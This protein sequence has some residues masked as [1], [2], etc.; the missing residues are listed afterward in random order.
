WFNEPRVFPKEAST[1]EGG[2]RSVAGVAPSNDRSIYEKC[3]KK[4]SVLLLSRLQILLNSRHSSTK[5]D[6]VERFSFLVSE[7]LPIHE[8]FLKIG[9]MVFRYLDDNMIT[10]G[11]PKEGEAK[12][13]HQCSHTMKTPRAFPKNLPKLIWHLA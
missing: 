6:Y 3:F 13:C 7:D 2:D 1:S 8:Y 12:C 5:A 9:G 4:K 10:A 11:A